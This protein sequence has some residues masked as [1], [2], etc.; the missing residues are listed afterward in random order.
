MFFCERSQEFISIFCDEDAVTDL[1]PVV[2]AI[3]TSVHCE[4]HPLLQYSLIPVGKLRGCI[5][6]K[7]DG[8]PGPERNR[9]SCA[10]DR[11]CICMIDVFRHGTRLHFSKC[12]CLGAFCSLKQLLSLLIYPADKQYPVESRIESLE[13]SRPAMADEQRFAVFEAGHPVSVMAHCGQ[14]PGC[15]DLLVADGWKIERLFV[16][17]EL[18]HQ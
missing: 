8:S 1:C 15:H 14:T 5:D 7:A 11:F 9:V 13:L 2:S 12:G 6:R 3:G 17:I 10:L 18:S 16:R 4:C